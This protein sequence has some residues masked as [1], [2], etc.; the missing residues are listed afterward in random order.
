MNDDHQVLGFLQSHIATGPNVLPLYF[1][2]DG[3]G[4]LTLE[5]ADFL[6]SAWEKER[7]H[8]E[9]FEKTNVPAY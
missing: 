3:D 2:K 4:N 5:L 1:F 7:I 6:E 8:S 9:I